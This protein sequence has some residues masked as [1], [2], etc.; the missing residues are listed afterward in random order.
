M[1]ERIKYNTSRLFA[2]ILGLCAGLLFMFGLYN[3]MIKAFHLRIYGLVFIVIPIF[4]GIYGKRIYENW[5]KA[6]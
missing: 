5:H 6:K 1:K 2:F 4:S 3:F